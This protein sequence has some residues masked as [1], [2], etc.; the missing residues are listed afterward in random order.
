MRAIIRKLDKQQELNTE[1]YQSLMGYIQQLRM[2]SLP[3]YQVFYQRYAGVLYKQYST[4]LPEFEYTLGDAV[5]LLAEQ[6]E[7]LPLALQ[8]PVQWQHFPPPYRPYLQA[9]AQNRLKGQ[10]FYEVVRQMADKPES[11]VSLPR[12]REAEVVMLF[13]DQ[14]PFKE[15]GLKAHFDR[16]SR[17]TFMTRLQSVRYLTRHKAKQDRVEVLA[18]DRLGGIFT[19]KEKSIY[20][21]IYLTESVEARA[22]KACALL[23]LALYGQ[24]M[25]DGH[26]I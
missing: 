12:P 7:L 21:Y 1:E 23:N 17:F 6:P 11:P 18:P 14:N 24:V 15:R 25:G 22:R 9:C 20:Y 19:N 16:L 3:S 10:L 4:Y 2:Q 13:E 26:D 5:A 8:R